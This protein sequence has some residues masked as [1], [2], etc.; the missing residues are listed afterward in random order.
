[1]SGPFAHPKPTLQDGIARRN[2]IDCRTQAFYAFYTFSTSF[3]ASE[4]SI[5]MGK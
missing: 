3:E 2:T 5:K 4:N 1:M